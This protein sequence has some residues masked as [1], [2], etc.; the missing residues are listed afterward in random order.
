M[1][2]DRR[3]ET[4]ETDGGSDSAGTD[5]PTQS[6]EPASAP[7]TPPLS[8][9]EQAHVLLVTADSEYASTCA[10]E[11][12]A[13]DG[14]RV[15]PTA[16]VAEA[17]A[18]LDTADTVEC[19]ISDHDT[20]DIDAIAFLEA[21]RLKYLDLPFILFTSEGSELIASRAIHAGVTDY[22]IK[23][24]YRDQWDKLMA[25]ITQTIAYY[26]THTATT[27]DTESRREPLMEAMPDMVGV[28]NEGR[29][30]YVN[31]AGV[32]L[33]GLDQAADLI[34]TPFLDLFTEKTDLAREQIQAIQRGDRY[35]GRLE[36]RLV[37]VAGIDVPV[38]ITISRIPWRG[39]MATLVIVSDRSDRESLENRLRRVARINSVVREINH[40]IIMA[41]SRQEIERETCERLVAVGDYA[42]AWIGGYDPETGRV[43]PREAAGPATDYLDE[44]DITVGEEP[45][46]QGPTGRAIASGEVQVSQDI[47]E[48]PVMAPWHESTTVYGFRATIAIPLT[49]EDTRYGILNVYLQR[50]GGFNEVERD[51]FAVLGQ[52]IAFAIRALDTRV[53]LERSEERLALALEAAQAG[54]WDWHLDT[55]EV[56]WD[57]SVEALFG[58]GPGEF[59]GTYEAFADRVHPDDLSRIEMAISRAIEETS[60]FESQFRIRR[61]DGALRWIKAQG[62]VITDERGEPQRI[63]GVDVDITEQKE[64]EQHLQVI[65]RVLRHNLHNSLNVIGGGAATIREQA[66]G[67][68]A[69]LADTIVEQSE[70]LLSTADKERK[71]VELLTEPP[72]YES[73]DLAVLVEDAVAALESEYPEAEVETSVRGDVE[74]I[75]T[76][77]FDLVVSEL[78]ENAI[79]HNDQ[80]PPVVRVEVE[81]VSEGVR[82]RVLDNGPGIPPMNI[83]VLTEGS[84]KPLYHGSGLGLWLVHWVVQRCHGTLD[85]DERQPR[86][87][88]VTV[89]LPVRQVEEL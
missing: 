24:H 83:D 84:E 27:L 48:D 34:G 61:P 17:M 79:I 32:E 63:L 7:S 59:E 20:P 74:A 57:E 6:R 77:R 10:R 18:V 45:T 68:V 82:L 42:L 26:R 35:I 49:V 56:I 22:L 53:N 73:V 86:G 3:R 47:T 19:I 46:G 28:L 40:L 1:C 30:E 55:D 50:P 11:L 65:D 38:E 2:P 78:V 37:D 43:E 9:G 8:D 51:T 75:V 69:K 23:E 31:T 58:L 66:T 29:F 12:A 25:L 89:A 80:E 72:E 60:R 16:T 44:V 15:T 76:D 36:E 54:V 62:D 70:R 39:E 13:R 67:D 4:T 33:L 21:V 52:D 88:V 85:F 64:R 41:E 87:N 5:T 14:I 81:P 71:I